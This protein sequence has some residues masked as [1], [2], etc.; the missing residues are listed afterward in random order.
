MLSDI[1]GQ[2]KRDKYLLIYNLLK[3]RNIFGI[4]YGKRGIG[5]R[6]IINKAIRS[7]STPEDR[8]VFLE[9]GDNIYTSILRELGIYEHE[10]YTKEDFLIY[11][12]DFVE[13][14]K[15]RI[16]IV[17]NNAQKFTEKEL[18]EIFHLLSLKERVSTILIGD[19]TL[20]EKLN[21]FKIGKM[22]AA[23]NF[24]FEINP[25]EFEEFKRY[26]DEKYGGKIEKKA[27]KKLYQISGG[28]LSDAENIIIQLGKFP[29]KASDLKTKDKN[30][31]VMI[32]VLLLTIAITV[33][34]SYM[35]L[36]PE[37]EKKEIKKITVID[38]KLPEEGSVI[39]ELP[40]KPKKKKGFDSDRLIKEVLEEL[41]KIQLQD[42][43]ELR[44]Y[45]KPKKYIIQIASF[46]NEQYALELKE[47]L[48]KK[49][50]AEI[51]TRKNGIKSVIV[52]ASNKKEVD[53]IINELNKM[54]FKPLVRKV[55]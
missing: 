2:D 28:S 22:E 31:P 27:L 15:G 39:N 4:V 25:P 41:S 12:I 49:F 14:F 19:E 9:A 8:V 13:K 23:V 10:I 24:V 47:R 11:F 50:L 1:Y 51:I 52:F 21:P 54:G 29:I 18:S 40:V 5:K 42:V 34:I 7:I 48:S 3:D 36:K 53:N 30:L 20:K 44:F 38:K 33:V 43:P 46:K 17:I 32:S 16:F 26:F 35:I 6:F 37:E 45:E 55:K